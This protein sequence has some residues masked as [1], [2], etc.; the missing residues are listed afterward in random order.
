MRRFS[1]SHPNMRSMM[2]QCR[3]LGRSNS[4]AK[5]GLGL[6]LMSRAGSPVAS[7]ND[8]SNG[9]KLQRHLFG[10]QPSAA[11]AWTTTQT[12]DISLIQQRLSISN[13]ASLSAEI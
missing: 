2:L 8:H 3:Y 12:R 5:P 10:Q 4:L 6:R 1:F 7:D 11:F 9:A 13:I